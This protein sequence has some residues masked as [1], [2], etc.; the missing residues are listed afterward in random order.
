[1]PIGA[2][3]G[4]SVAGAGIGALGASSAANTQA[5][6]ATQAA[7]LQQQS[8][9]AAQAQQLQMYNQTRSD[10][11][12][13]MNTGNAA[14]SQLASLFGIGTGGPTAA[15]A[16]AATSALTQT[17]GYQFGLDQGVQALDR[18]SA[19]R[20]LNLSGAQ[21]KDAQTFG[22]G[23]AQ[24]QAWQPYVS[25]LTGLAGM[26]QNAAAGVGSNGLATANSITNSITG[27]GNAGAAGIVGAG[28]A[29][30]SGTVGTANA[31]SGGLQN[32]LLAYQLYGNGG[33][34]SSY[35]ASGTA[36][37]STSPLGSVLASLGG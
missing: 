19:S 35:N 7:Q 27:A 31:L 29:G 16:A 4:A 34:G 2:A 13:Y 12:P 18:S 25:S 15:T 8:A 36:G 21:L 26:G 32:S 33:A 22:Q 11:S 1:M 23:Y 3:I 17:P 28:Q 24:Q 14:L 37:D 20:G 30:A 5:N 10:L 9:A 6:A